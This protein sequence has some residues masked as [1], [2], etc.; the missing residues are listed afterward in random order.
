M[1][2]QSIFDAIKEL[3]EGTTITS[4]DHPR[5]KD[6]AEPAMDM[7]EAI[8]NEDDPHL[9]GNGWILHNYDDEW[10]LMDSSNEAE[11]EAQEI[12]TIY[13]LNEGPSNELVNAL[14]ES[15][16]RRLKK[17]EPDLMD[18]GI[19]S[20]S[21]TGWSVGGS[22]DYSNFTGNKYFWSWEDTNSEL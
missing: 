13:G 7:W 22:K 10:V 15:S 20:R 4:E 11:Q 12:F 8:Q 14:Q 17:L 2:K 1:V 18:L 16:E 5:Y 21:L 19:I 3:D 9:V 6:V